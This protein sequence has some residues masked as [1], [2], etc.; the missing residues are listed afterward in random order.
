MCNRR[1]IPIKVTQIDA[2]RAVFT[3]CCIAPTF[4]FGGPARVFL[5]RAR[6]RFCQIAQQLQY[7]SNIVRWIGQE[8]DQCLLRVRSTSWCTAQRLKDFQKGAVRDFICHVAK[9]NRRR[10]SVLSTSKIFNV[11]WLVSIRQHPWGDYKSLH[12]IRLI[13][14][15]VV[16]HRCNK[17]DKVGLVKKNKMRKKLRRDRRK[18]LSPN[19][20][21]KT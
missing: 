1:F 14:I 9:L 12:R 10:C 5:R 15:H 8:A 20:G 21:S 19:D 16:L 4:H 6:V 2:S 3:M 17:V 7:G 13:I 11:R 18:D